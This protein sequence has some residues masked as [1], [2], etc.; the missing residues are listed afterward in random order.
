[1]FKIIEWEMLMTG[2]F[3]WQMCEKIFGA[4]KI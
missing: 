1:M 2:Y 4:G 3:T